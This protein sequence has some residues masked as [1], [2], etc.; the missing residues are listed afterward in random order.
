MVTG[1]APRRPY[2]R[3]PT[4]ARMAFSGLQIRD[5]VPLFSPALLPAPSQAPQRAVGFLPIR[6]AILLVPISTTRRAGTVVACDSAPVARFP[7][8]KDATGIIAIWSCSYVGFG[9][10]GTVAGL[11]RV[12]RAAP[13]SLRLIL[14]RKPSGPAAANRWLPGAG[15]EAASAVQCRDFMSFR[16][17]DVGGSGRLAALPDADA[18]GA[19]PPVPLQQRV[20]QHDSRRRNAAAND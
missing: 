1:A 14:G 16:Q 6:Q 12:A 20:Q 9:M 18:A 11:F 7:W 3:R 19:F 2:L 15:R 8:R 4:D 13:P 10:T 17:Q 5:V